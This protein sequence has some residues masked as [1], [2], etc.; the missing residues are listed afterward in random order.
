MKLKVQTWDNKA[1]GEITLD[2]D[3]FGLPV[4]EDILNAM[5]KY[6]LAK[7]RAGTHKTKTRSEVSATGQKSFNQKGT[8][9]ARASTLD[10]VRHRGGGTVH[11]PTPRDHSHSLNKKTRRLA[12]KTALSAKAASGQLIVVKD[13]ALKSHKTKPMADALTKM[14]VSNAV[15]VTGAVIDANFDR[16][17]NNIPCIDVF[18]TSGANV[19]DILRR[20]NLILTQEAV[21]TLTANLKG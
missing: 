13:A 21:D 10:T 5:V 15:V 3:V 16:A 9:R 11:G 2:K 14:G 7:R 12:M 4:R 6:Q 19:Y 1:G 8:G 20:E 18:S 17:T